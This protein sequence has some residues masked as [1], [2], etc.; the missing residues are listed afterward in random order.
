[1]C[2]RRPSA[3]RGAFE[4]HWATVYGGRWPRLLRALA[5]PTEHL[6]WINPF[7]ARPAGGVQP[8][9][10]GSIFA[11]GRGCH[12][13]LRRGER[14]VGVPSDQLTGGRGGS[15]DDQSTS[16]YSQRGAETG[17]GGGNQ[18]VGMAPWQD[19]PLAAQTLTLNQTYAL[20][21]AS[22]LPALALD[23]K[24]G[25]RVLD[26]CAA[27]GGKS[28][29]LAGLLF[30]R[31]RA[32]CSRLG[33]GYAHSW[34]CASDSGSF[35]RGRTLSHCEGGGEV[36]AAGPQD[37][38]YCNRWVEGDETSHIS[39]GRWSAPRAQ[40]LDDGIRATSLL[41]CND[42]S[43]GRQARLN[44]TLAD[45]LPDTLLQATQ[46]NNDHG[47]PLERTEP[48]LASPDL[49]S[50]ILDAEYSGD[51]VI[52]TRF[53]AATF[54]REDGRQARP[55]QNT[56]QNLREGAK[57]LRFDRILL[58]APCSSERHIIHQARRDSAGARVEHSMGLQREGMSRAG[59][60]RACC[61]PGRG[62]GATADCNDLSFSVDPSAWSV[63][64]L[65][66]DATSQAAMLF[67]AAS[68]LAPGGRL[69]YSTCSID[70]GQNDG[71]VGRLLKHRRH[72]A[73]LFVA[74]PLAALMRICNTSYSE[75]TDKPSLGRIVPTHES[76][77]ATSY[78]G[79]NRLLEGVELTEFGAI[80]L[81]DKSCLGFGPMYWAI[82]ERNVDGLQMAL[83]D[84]HVLANV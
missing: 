18:L 59:A 12:L 69:V 58:D 3:R 45:F 49:V 19:T 11:A 38:E 27:P 68:L 16:V 9:Q 83:A 77:T 43:R 80:L 32:L 2:R 41:V 81:P 30:G 36:R 52:T 55:Y 14:R 15:T 10:L 25:H 60:A 40:P 78:A 34:A 84:A 7:T 8:E 5:A 63:S 23:V 24:P 75:Q 79:L 50:D 56:R 51:R 37:E 44:K 42:R 28:L 72:G 65:R 71:T 35:E 47:Q 73:G 13:A 54:G 31:D 76:D 57:R 66:R 4:Q 21:G 39:P 29:V 67:N 33:G 61:Q 74:D 22:P 64:R 17:K 70:P 20:D 48:N 6:L 82:I 53:D 62:D 46:N 1:M 26:M